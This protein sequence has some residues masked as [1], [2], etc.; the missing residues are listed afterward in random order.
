MSLDELLESY[1][2]EN[3]D[4]KSLNTE[5]LLRIVVNHFKRF[6]GGSATATDL[7]DRNLVGFMRWRRQGGTA[8]ITIEHEVAKIRALAVFAHGLGLVPP[9]R[10]K[11]KH[12]RPA[13]PSAMTVEQVRAMFEAARN[14][15]YEIGGVPG[16]VYFVALFHLAWD[17]GA[18]ANSIHELKRDDID[19]ENR[20]VTFRVLK[21]NAPAVTKEIRQSAA[22][23]I[24]AL[25]EVSPFPRPFAVVKPA[26]IYHHLKRIKIA[27]GIPLSRR[28]GLHDFRRA[29]ATHL[30]AAG[31]DATEALGH[32]SD[33]VT[34]KWYIDPRAKKKQPV[35]LLFDPS[36][37]KRANWFAWL[38]NAVGLWFA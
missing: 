17:T 9:V 15:P 5:R 8:E 19:L 25:L 13:T 6:L 35:D 1:L 20:R 27:A 22:D 29:Y 33:A 21:G 28:N 32:S 34:R 36:A 16:A 30:W 38:R 7:I 37:P 4:V 12:G 18:R 24:R 23:A 14:N 11:V 26:S 10:F 3:G 2:S 31:G